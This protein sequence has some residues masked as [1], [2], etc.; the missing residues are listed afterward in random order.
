MGR[1]VDSE[2]YRDLRPGIMIVS[3]GLNEEPYTL[4]TTSG[5]FI[6]RKR[7]SS[8]SEMGY[9]GGMLGSIFAS[10]GVNGPSKGEGDRGRR[11]RG[12]CR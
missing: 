12:D 9:K 7:F 11:C 10:K 4:M 8:S 3:M 1:R 5:V 6:N 2:V